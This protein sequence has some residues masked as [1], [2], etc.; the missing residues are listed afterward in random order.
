MNSMALRQKYYRIRKKYLVKDIQSD[1]ISILYQLNNNSSKFSQ[2]VPKEIY[3]TSLIRYTVR[4]QTSWKGSTV[5]ELIKRNAG[6]SRQLVLGF[7]GM[8]G[9]CH[10]QKSKKSI[11]SDVGLSDNSCYSFFDILHTFRQIQVLASLEVLILP[12]Q[13][14]SIL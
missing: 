6:F 12:R 1:H 7:V 9:E 11:T 13:V 2:V 10:L 4:M 8:C 3:S 14:K 5:F